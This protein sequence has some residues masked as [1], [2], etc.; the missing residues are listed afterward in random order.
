MKKFLEF[1]NESFKIG[2]RVKYDTYAQNF[3]NPEGVENGYVIDI[4]ENG[5][6][7]VKFDKA[8]TD[9]LHDAEGMDPE[10][11]SYW[12]DIERLKKARPPKIVISSEDPY[13]EEDWGD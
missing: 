3:E 10:S 13:G 2:S 9:C 12:C 7:L 5:M 4:D 6:I 11:M 1:I 8:W